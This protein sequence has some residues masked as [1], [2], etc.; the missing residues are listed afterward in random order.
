LG[1]TQSLLPVLKSGVPAAR[2]Q[3]E[4]FLSNKQ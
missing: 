3:F 4:R 2:A 1:N